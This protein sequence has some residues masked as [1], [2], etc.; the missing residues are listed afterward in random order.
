MMDQ[1]PRGNQEDC[2][3][4]GGQV[5]Q[6]AFL[7]EAVTLEEPVVSAAVFDGLGGHSS[8]EKTSRLAAELLAGR[9]TEADPDFILTAVRQVQ[10]L[11][12]KRADLADG[13]TTGAGVVVT[14][15]RA[16]VWSVGDSR[17]YRL[18]PSGLVRASRDH[19]FVQ[20]MVDEGLISE[21][22]AFTSPYRN[23]VDFGIGPGFDHAWTNHEVFFHV[24]ELKGPAAWMLCTDGV[25][26]VLTDPAMEKVLSPG[27]PDQAP[28][29][30]EALRKK[31]LKDNTSFI[32]LQVEDC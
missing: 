18:S 10:E 27:S 11:S 2:L 31:G 23:L 26:D 8:G 14:K 32:I 21:E 28:D 17:V 1:G 6:S 9:L 30:M 3:L 5:F 4:A 7:D 20:R 29:L 15:G 24:E 16:V 25:C 12:E 22:E 13:G 19:S